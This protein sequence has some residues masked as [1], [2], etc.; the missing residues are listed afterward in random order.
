MSEVLLC[1]VVILAINKE[2]KVD[3][4][5]CQSHEGHMWNQ[6]EP[7]VKEASDFIFYSLFEVKHRCN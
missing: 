7:K 1:S 6:R 3:S 4:E 5:I 2:N